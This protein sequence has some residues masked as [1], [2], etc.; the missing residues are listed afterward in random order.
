MKVLRYLIVLVA[1]TAVSTTFF[2]CDRENDITGKPVVDPNEE[3]DGKRMYWI[4]FQLSNAGS[5]SQAAQDRFVELRDTV[6]YGD[7]GIKIIEHPMYV[8]KDYALTNFNKV[9]SLPNSESDLV[10]KIMKPTSEFGGANIRDFVVTMS[11][12]VD[13]MKT[14]IATHDF[15]AAD[16]L[17]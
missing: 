11:L 6:I 15:R 14:V 17:N 9:V 12:S 1:M 13:S 10:Q 16:V 5:L 4:D 2:S 8:T 7:K 3:V